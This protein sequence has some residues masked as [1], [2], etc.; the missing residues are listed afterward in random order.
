MGG[1]L[2]TSSSAVVYPVEDR[3][4]NGVEACSSRWPHSGPKALG[5]QQFCKHSLLVSK[6]AK[7]VTGTRGNTFTAA[8]AVVTLLEEG[9]DRPDVATCAGLPLAT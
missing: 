7:F 8:L 3:S 1:T 6:S 4:A 2:L 9:N 5:G